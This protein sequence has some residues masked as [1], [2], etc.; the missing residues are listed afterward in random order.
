M[1]KKDI[2]LLTKKCRQILF[3]SLMLTT[4]FALADDTANVERLS[5]FVTDGVHVYENRQLTQTPV[6]TLPSQISVNFTS[7]T[8]ANNEIVW[9]WHLKN[10]ASTSLN[11]LRVTGLIDIDINAPINTFFN[12]GGDLVSLTAPNDYIRSDKWEI[13]EPGYL[14]GDL[15]LR[16]GKGNLKNTSN[17]DEDDSAIALS[18]NIGSLGAGE[19]LDIIAKLSPEALEG[20]KQE[21]YS[22]IETRLQKG[23][24]G[25]V[26][27]TQLNSD[28]VLFNFYAKKPG[29]SRVYTDMVQGALL[30]TGT[31]VKEGN[32]WVWGFR[33]SSQQGNGKASVPSN[34]APAKVNSLSNIVGLTGG[35]YH[36]IALDDKGNVYGW[37]QNG[38]G[39]TGCA[40]TD[41]KNVPCKVLANAVQLGAGEYFSMALDAEGQVWTWGYNNYGQLGS[42]DKKNSK[43]PIAVNLNGEK[44]RLIGAAYE[45]GFAVTNEGHVWAWGDNEASGLGFQGPK[46]GYQQIIT[47]PTRVPNLE[48]YADR[49]TY[50]AGGNGWGEA[51][52][53]DG[54]VIGWG[55]HA[56]LGQGMLDTDVSSPEPVQVFN[57]V[58]QLYARYIGSI[59]LTNDGKI[60]TWGQT[61]GSSFQMIYGASPTLRTPYNNEPVVAVGG[62]KE[63]VYYQTANGAMYGVGYNDL[64]KIDQTTC[65]APNVDWPGKGIIINE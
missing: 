58:K 16:A 47:T 32:V 18:A 23:V 11:N 63:N 37:G 50:I 39:Q 52:L 20:V 35:A 30:T 64:Y 27:T 5:L 25:S 9:Q 1:L 26:K 51:L 65:C 41:V 22:R 43:V 46:Y 57:N 42:G 14:T 56:S 59:A 17:L 4:P 21:D 34:A 54:S 7:T 2:K 15:I 36:L 6:N 60:Y 8:N 38:Y 55:V 48:P 28:Q 29:P 13:G 53:N 3:S 10:N 49:I 33:G 40:S 45:G 19:E 44:T 12:E 31:A 61:K 62:G 24:N